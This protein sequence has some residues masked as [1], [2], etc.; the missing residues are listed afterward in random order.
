MEIFFVCLKE[1]KKAKQVDSEKEEEEDDEQQ[2]IVGVKK[3][4]K[5]QQPV[6]ARENI[7]GLKFVKKNILD[8]K[9]RS[10]LVCFEHNISNGTFFFG[11][12]CLVFLSDFSKFFFFGILMGN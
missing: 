3:E 10:A 6:R 12:V 7:F 2:H 8:N 11:L 1:K 9:R 4:R 5:I